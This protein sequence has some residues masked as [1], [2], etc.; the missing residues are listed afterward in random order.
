MHRDGV[1]V[2]KGRMKFKCPKISHKMAASPV[3]AKLPAPMQ[4]TDARFIWL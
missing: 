1:E 2:A 3:P 4:N